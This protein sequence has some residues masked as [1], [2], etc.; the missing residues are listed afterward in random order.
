MAEQQ[1]VRTAQTDTQGV[2]NFVG[3]LPGHYQLTF[4]AKGFQT[5]VQSGITLTVGQNARMDATMTVGTVRSEV[6][7]NSSAPL[8]DTVSPALSGLM[9]DR[10]VVDLPLNGRNVMGLANILPGVTN[11]KASQQMGDARGGP[12][13]NVNG[14]RSNMNMFTFNG[15]FFNNPSRNTGI[16][17]PPPDAIQEVRILTHNFAAEFGHNPGSQVEVLSKAEAISLPWSPLG[18]PAKRP[19][20]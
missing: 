11:V 20:S 9:T 6:E 10:R 15:G 14:G 16:N 1:S 18:V 5:A 8:V 7:V 17:Y 2:Y 19:A 3:L 13:M 4:E 12:Q